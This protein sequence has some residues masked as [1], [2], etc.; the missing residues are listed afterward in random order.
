T[1]VLN[2]LNTNSQNGCG[3]GLF[4]TEESRLRNTEGVRRKLLLSD[5]S[6]NPHSAYFLMGAHASSL[7]QEKAFDQTFVNIRSVRVFYRKNFIA[8]EK[9]TPF[10]M[11][12]A[13]ITTDGDTNMVL[14]DGTTRNI[15]SSDQSLYLS[16]EERVLKRAGMV[17]AGTIT[18]TAQGGYNS[19]RKPL[20]TP[21]SVYVITTTAPQ[22][23]KYGFEARDFLVTKN[24]PTGM[25]AASEEYHGSKNR[26]TFNA[27]SQAWQQ[28]REKNL[29]LKAEGK[30]FPSERILKET[31]PG[32]IN[33]DVVLLINGDFFLRKVLQN[34]LKIYLTKLVIPAMRLMVT[35]TIPSYIKATPFGT[36]FF[37]SL[38]MGSTFQTSLKPYVLD[39]LIKTYVELLSEGEF[40]PQATTLEFAFC[41]EKA[42]DVLLKAATKAKVHIVWHPS[43]D[44]CDFSPVLSTNNE[45][46]DPMRY[47]RVLFDASN[48]FS[49]DGNEPESNSLTSMLANNS[50]LRLVFNWHFNYL[51]LD[52]QNHIPLS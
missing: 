5:H 34:A 37:A 32:S 49:F 1:I 48:V 40:C 51:L 4:P 26:P 7:I 2:F 14:P 35:S 25:T 41:G 10:I 3:W 44:L 12:T 52:S 23:E 28:I 47:Q 43:R 24:G 16:D 18:L 42:P 27:L 17:K 9:V 22:F 29:P 30:P 13:M 21:I 33:A 45:L 38:G 50:D 46:I 39:A 31:H 19:P 8:P 6:Y 36:D 15:A 11:K 20:N